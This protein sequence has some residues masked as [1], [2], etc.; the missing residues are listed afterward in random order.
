MKRKDVNLRLRPLLLQA[1]VCL[2]TFHGGALVSF[3]V[4]HSTASVCLV[5]HT[6]THTKSMNTPWPSAEP[7]PGRIRHT[8]FYLSHEAQRTSPRLTLDKK[9]PNES[10]RPEEPVCLSTRL[11]TLTGRRR[12]SSSS[13]F[14]LSSDFLSHAGVTTSSCPKGS[15]LLPHGAVSTR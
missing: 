1:I 11:H 4:R 2:Q 5:Q 9:K 6:H 12:T 15:A 14:S 7:L 13:S 8:T 3:L 10:E